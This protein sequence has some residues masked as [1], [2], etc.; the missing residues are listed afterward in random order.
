MVIYTQHCEMC[1]AS[2]CQCFLEKNEYILKEDLL[3]WLACYGSGSSTKSAFTTERL[4]VLELPS[5]KGWMPRQSQY[6][7][8]GPGDC[9]ELWVFS[10]VG[11][12][13]KLGSRVSAGQ[14]S[15]NSRSSSNAAVLSTGTQEGWQPFSLRS[16][17]ISA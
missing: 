15:S 6:S 16:F 14:S 1:L 13:R 2:L 11:K 12:P 10:C 9:S 17:R 4:R 5:L 7:S 3:A 8:E